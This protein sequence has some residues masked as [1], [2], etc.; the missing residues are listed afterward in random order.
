V[1]G[2]VLGGVLG[3]I[4]W[5]ITRGNPY[6]LAI[7]TFFLMIPLYYLFFTSQVLNIVAIMTKVTLLLVNIV[8]TILNQ[9]LYFVYIFCIHYFFQKKK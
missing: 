1:A 9:V 2:T 8:I 4:V 3:I 7:L 5:E 6:G